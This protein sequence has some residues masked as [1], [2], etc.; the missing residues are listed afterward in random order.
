MQL[1]QIPFVFCQH[2][3][4]VWI[5]PL[6]KMNAV[7]SVSSIIQRGGDSKRPDPFWS[8]YLLSF[9][10]STAA[11]ASLLTS[12]YSESTEDPRL[13]W[14]RTHKACVQLPPSLQC[15]DT[16]SLRSLSAQGLVSFQDWLRSLTCFSPALIKPKLQQTF[17]N[18]TAKHQHCWW[19]NRW[20]NMPKQS[21]GQK[22]RENIQ[23]IMNRY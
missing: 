19:I 2:R 5:H 16:N 9:P 8:P 1:L 4:W 20:I 15:S 6:S 14:G 21:V 11:C 17:K 12:R 22:L 3:K 7:G 13:T 18:G 23:I 10:I